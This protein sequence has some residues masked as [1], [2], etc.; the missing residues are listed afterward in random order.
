MRNE[1]LESVNITYCGRV[2][3]DRTWKSSICSEM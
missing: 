3:V 1:G 2:K